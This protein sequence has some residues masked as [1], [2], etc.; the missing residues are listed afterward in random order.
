MECLVYSNNILEYKFFLDH[1]VIFIRKG[2]GIRPQERCKNLYHL[3]VSMANLCDDSLSFIQENLYFGI[4]TD[5]NNHE[6]GKTQRAL[7]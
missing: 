3:P 5:L 2:N 4:L 6:I 7:L 1:H